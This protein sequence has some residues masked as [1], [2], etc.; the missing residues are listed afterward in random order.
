MKIGER[1][2]WAGSPATVTGFR[3]GCPVLRLDVVV[4]V[5][6]SQF[7]SRLG[8]RSAEEVARQQENLTRLAEAVLE[9]IGRT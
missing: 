1:T 4:T 9:R 6:A 7:D 3:H 8:A 5:E 2:W